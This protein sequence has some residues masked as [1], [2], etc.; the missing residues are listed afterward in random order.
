MADSAIWLFAQAPDRMDTI[1]IAIVGS[2][3]VGKSSFIQK[4]LRLTKFPTANTSSVRLDLEGIPHIVCLMEFDVEYFD[5]DDVVAPGKQIKWPKQINGQQVP[6]VD[7]ALVLYDV[8]NKDSIRELPPALSELQNL[9]ATTS[10]VWADE[11]LGA[12]SSTSIPIIIVAN[13]CDTPENLRQLDTAGVARLANTYTSCI[14]EFKTSVNAPASQRDCLQAILKA[15]LANRRGKKIVS[16]RR[17]THTA[18]VQA[19]DCQLV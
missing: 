17:F 2:Q 11:C 7:G 14:G 16:F 5:I 8:T 4:S 12:M 19:V 3:G 10:R 9:R 18:N 1:N 15:A 13:K 6:R